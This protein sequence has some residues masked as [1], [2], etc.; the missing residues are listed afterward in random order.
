MKADNRYDVIPSDLILNNTVQIVYDSINEPA[1]KVV[2][3][4]WPVLDDTDFVPVLKREMA[5][6]DIE[7]ELNVWFD[8]RPLPLPFIS[9]ML[10]EADE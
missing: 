4:G 7:Y 8:V 10:D 5:P 1:Q 2:V 9:E 6:A 3:E